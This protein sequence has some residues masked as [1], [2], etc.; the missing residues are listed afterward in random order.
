MKKA[1]RKKAPAKKKAARTV[2]KKPVVIKTAAM[3]K[4]I[5]RV[6]HYYNKIRV[7]I[8]KFKCDVRV[9]THLRFRGATTD[10]ATAVTSMQFDHQPVQVA[11]KNKLIGIRVSKRVRE[12]DQVFLEG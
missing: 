12:G 11:K 7:A 2:R 10:F 4:P 6:T 1:V 5:G 9:G 8:V 3:P